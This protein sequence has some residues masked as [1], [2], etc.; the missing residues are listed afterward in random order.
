M[1]CTTYKCSKGGSGRRPGGKSCKE[2]LQL[3]EG[4]CLP[5]THNQKGQAYPSFP[6]GLAP[7]KQHCFRDHASYCAGGFGKCSGAGPLP[8]INM[9]EAV[10]A[11]LAAVEWVV[12]DFK[13]MALAK[14]SKTNTV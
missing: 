11:L 5:R 14:T 6:E 4:S 8:A 1:P 12:K 2:P 10:M 9:G 3:P 7:L 13:P